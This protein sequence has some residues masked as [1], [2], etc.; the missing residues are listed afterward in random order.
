MISHVGW[1]A[2]EAPLLGMQDALTTHGITARSTVAGVTDGRG[3]RFIVNPRAGSPVARKPIDV[4]R[5]R[6]PGAALVELDGERTC[7]EILSDEPVPEVAGAVGGDGTVS[8]VAAAAHGLHLGLAVIPAGTLNHFAHDLGLHSVDDGIDAVVAGTRRPVD[9]AEIDE[10]CF[11]NNASIGAYPQ[12]VD[13]R[14]RF[15]RYVGKW[16]A[17]VIALMVELRRGAPSNVVIDGR[18]RRLWFAFFGNCR[19]D[20]EG[21]AAPAG[22]TH[23]DDGLID[24]RMVH[25]DRKFARLRLF[26]CALLRRLDRCSVYEATAVSRITVRSTSGPLRLAAD[27]ETFDGSETF[28][29]KKYPSALAVFANSTQ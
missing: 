19:Y 27:G 11:V 14:E 25:A 4:L 12:I 6:L 5:E 21:I 29:I 18:P 8:S 16:P 9:L 20:R 13:T 10:H 7:A 22:R 24:V 1:S 23:L 26:T 15:R 17:L 2:C 28:E 3:I